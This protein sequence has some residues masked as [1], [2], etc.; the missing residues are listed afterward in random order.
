MMRLLEAY[1][2]E[3]DSALWRECDTAML[4]YVQQL[5]ALSADA[6]TPQRSAVVKA[7]EA[8]SYLKRFAMIPADYPPAGHL[9][10]IVD[11][12]GWG[13]RR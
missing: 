11:Q 5:Q 2:Y 6:L 1:V 4:A 7:N 3:N 12:Q 9:Q 10:Q 8:L 13:K